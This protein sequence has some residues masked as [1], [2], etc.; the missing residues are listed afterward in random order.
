MLTLCPYPNE[1]MD[2]RPLFESQTLLVHQPHP[3]SHNLFYCPIANEDGPI[4]RPNDVLLAGSLAPE[5]YPLRNRL[6]HLQAKQTI[7]G[8]SRLV[9]FCR[10]LTSRQSRF[11]IIQGTRT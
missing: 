5:L 4:A 1:C 2:Y 10:R 8:Q 6:W 7:N 9:E 11:A 3:V